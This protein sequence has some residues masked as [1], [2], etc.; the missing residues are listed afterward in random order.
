M[1]T[2]ILADERV[3]RLGR[4][5]RVLAQMEAHD[6]LVL[7]RQANIRYVTGTPQL[8]TAGTRPFGPGCVLVRETGDIH[9]LSTWDEGVPE[10]IPRENLYGITWNP[11]NLVGVLRQTGGA[12]TARRVG[13]DALSPLFSQFLPMA[14]P[15]ADLVDGEQAMRAARRIKTPEEIVVLRDSIRI[16][17][18]G[19]AAAVAEL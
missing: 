2:E 19:L 10:D 5:A 4:R 17:E 18:A 13:T 8:W 11:L 6:L 3:L 15:Q 9:L 14:F 1:A 7:G 12:A 16:A